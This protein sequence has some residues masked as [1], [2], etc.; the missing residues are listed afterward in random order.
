LIGIFF[1]QMKQLALR[2]TV[3]QSLCIT[4]IPL[5]LFLWLLIPM[6]CNEIF[7]PRDNLRR[8]HETQS[9]FMTD[10]EFLRAQPGPAL[11]E[12]LLRCYLAGKPYI[13]DPFN[14]T[15]LVRA[16]RLNVDTVVERIQ[17]QEYGAIQFK[18]PPTADGRPSA[19][20]ER[21]VKQI[22][23]ATAET[24]RVA[25][26]RKGCTIYV[27]K[28]PMKAVS[29]VRPQANATKSRAESKITSSSLK[30]SD[31]LQ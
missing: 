24:Y 26:V 1:G 29:A 10:V 3:N 7:W 21:F 2:S 18:D 15:S 25:F 30:H 27:P 16:G 9:R 11:C 23:D 6:Q 28:T 14:S 12:S 13:Y 5:L 19:T 31:L 8:I 17:K 4:G 22:L 20:P